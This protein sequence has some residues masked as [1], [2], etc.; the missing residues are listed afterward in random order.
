MNKFSNKLKKPCYWSIFPILMAKRT[1]PE[2]PALSR[3]TSHGILVPRQNLEKINDAIP[4]K[5]PDRGKDGSY[6]WV[7]KKLRKIL[8]NEHNKDNKAP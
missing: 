7:S 2:N 1:F 3:T 4:R 5:G 8:T 6:R